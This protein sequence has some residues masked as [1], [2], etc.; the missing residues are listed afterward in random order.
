MSLHHKYSQLIVYL[1]QWIT[2]SIDLIFCV[3]L[4]RSLGWAEAL[5]NCHQARCGVY[6]KQVLAFFCGTETTW[7]SVF[8]RIS[9]LFVSDKMP[10]PSSKAQAEKRQQKSPAKVVAEPKVTEEEPVP[11]EKTEIICPDVSGQEEADETVGQVK[12]EPEDIMEG[13]LEPPTVQQVEQWCLFLIW[14]K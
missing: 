5:A 4:V 2:L 11:S 14:A 9:Y 8:L 12:E 3:S 10:R 13:C 1:T 6:L 7:I